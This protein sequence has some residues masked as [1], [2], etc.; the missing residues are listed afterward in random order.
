MGVQP[1]FILEMTR[2]GLVNMRGT[3][4][5]LENTEHPVGGKEPN[6]W[7]LHDMYGNVSEWCQDWYGK[8]PSGSVTDPKGPP[9]G[10]ERMAR[11]GTW[12]G[13]PR[14]CSSAFRYM[15]APNSRFSGP[16]FRLVR[17][18]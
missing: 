1:R 4:I 5:T 16:G 2:I 17:N 8:Y 9:S 7:G 14:F 12:V 11:G 10:S 3:R 6:S 15:F 13:L 18:L